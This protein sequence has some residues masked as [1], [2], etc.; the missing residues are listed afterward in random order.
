MASPE[1]SSIELDEI[2]TFS[3]F[4]GKRL[5]DSGLRDTDEIEIQGAQ[6]KLHTNMGLMH[7]D[8][9]FQPT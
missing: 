3:A 6:Q 7:L 8:C 5:L 9:P 4:T 1:I 2:F